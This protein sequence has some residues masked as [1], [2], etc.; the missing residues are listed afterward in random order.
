MAH[1]KL[2]A[3]LG[4]RSSAASRGLPVRAARSTVLHRPVTCTAPRVASSQALQRPPPRHGTIR[5][6]PRARHG[7][8]Y[9]NRHDEA[10]D[11][12]P[13]A[14]RRRLGEWKRNGTPEIAFGVFVL[15]LAGVDHF[16]QER[17]RQH[18]Q[19]MHRQL[20]RDVRLDEEMR[21]EKERETIDE[22]VVGKSMFKCII[23]KVPQHFDGHKCLTNVEVG[24]VVDVIEEGVGPGGQYN[25]CSIDRGP[26]NT[27][28]SASDDGTRV[29]FGW[30]PCSC[31]EK[32]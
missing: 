29:S 30:F 32:C 27:E 4:A 3:A 26:E 15:A 31:L 22:A 9:R 20:G 1:M 25:L 18:R 19:S 14:F 23:R 11:S 5:D 24:D 2:A 10:G 13:S 17:N 16:L 21:R 8:R 7:Y 6:T 28:R 12:T